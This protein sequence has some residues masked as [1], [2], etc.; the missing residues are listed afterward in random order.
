MS[1]TSRLPGPMQV[2]LL[3]GGQRMVLEPF[4]LPPLLCVF[5]AALG[6]CVL[7][8]IPW[9]LRGWRL[10]LG[11]YAI[12]VPVESVTPMVAL[13]LPVGAALLSFGVVGVAQLLRRPMVFDQARGVFWRG[14]RGRAPANATPLSTINKLSIDGRDG[15]FRLTLTAQDTSFTLA[16]DTH[17][18]FV[19]NQGR[20]L[21]EFLSLP[22]IGQV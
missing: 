2:Q 13:A 21:A 19:A 16:S 20:Q 8:L 17:Q 18:E 14:W 6:V 12:S 5:V 7:M 1:R 22:L 4:P 10:P 11:S 15:Q 9:A 3:D